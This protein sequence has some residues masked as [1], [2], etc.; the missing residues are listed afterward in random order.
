MGDTLP[1]QHLEVKHAGQAVECGT[2]K[3]LLDAVLQHPVLVMPLTRTF[4]HGSLT[5]HQ[6]AIHITAR[7]RTLSPVY[8]AT[9]PAA[10]VVQRPSGFTFTLPT[11]QLPVEQVIQQAHLL[12]QQLQACVIELLSRSVRVSTVVAPARFRLPDAWVWSAR[13]EEPRLQYQSG[14]WVLVGEEEQR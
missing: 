2:L 8:Y 7:S 9:V 1:S 11:Q 14:S 13:C 10:E 12:Q 6:W 3:I 4:Q 5:I